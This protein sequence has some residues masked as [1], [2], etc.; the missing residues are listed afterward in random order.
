MDT[1]IRDVVVMVL[2][3]QHMNKFYETL[4][5][6]M[7]AERREAARQAFIEIEGSIV[8]DRMRLLSEEDLAKVQSFL[9]VS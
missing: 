8:E 5:E 2:H 1:F 4:I 9:K 7:G 6:E 3:D